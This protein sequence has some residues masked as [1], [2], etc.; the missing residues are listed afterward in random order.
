MQDLDREKRREQS[1]SRALEALEACA[2]TPFIP[3]E[4]VGWLAAVEQAYQQL[5]PLL[6]QQHGVHATEFAE[7]SRQDPE[8]LRHVENLEQEDQSI[9]V[10]F[11]SLKDRLELLRPLVCRVE[12]DEKRVEVVMSEFAQSAVTL[13]TR[14]RK[15]EVAVRTWLV[16]AFTRDRGQVD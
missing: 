9:A 1:L 2:G 12:P 15:Q 10:E 14:I 6:Q 16:E 7:M 8:M 5:Q 11:G 4:M 13:V 3:G